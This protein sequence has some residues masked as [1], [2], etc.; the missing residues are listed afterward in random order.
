MLRRGASGLS[1]PAKQGKT[2]SAEVKPRT[3]CVTAQLVLCKWPKARHREPRREPCEAPCPGRHQTWAW[4]PDSLWSMTAARAS[5]EEFRLQGWSWG[6][7]SCGPG[8]CACRAQ[9][10]ICAS[11][12]QISRESGLCCMEL[13][14]R[15]GSSRLSW[16]H[17]LHQE[18]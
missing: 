2:G 10:V 11:R 9:L 8:D 1:I 17:F 7:Q 14:D 3:G 13:C 4:A 12:P 6:S 16:L 15:G 18:N 5:Q